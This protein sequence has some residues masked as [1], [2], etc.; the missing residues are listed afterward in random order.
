MRSGFSLK[1]DGKEIQTSL[2]QEQS[3]HLPR[4][5][6]PAIDENTARK[7][8][9]QALI[10]K[11]IHDKYVRLYAEFENFRKRAVREREEFAAFCHEELIG[12]ILPFIDNLE[13]AIEPR[14]RS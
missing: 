6:E 11:N 10:A 12:E 7:D 5:Q 3:G 2:S 14:F 9:D 1:P 8:E 4:A 13:K